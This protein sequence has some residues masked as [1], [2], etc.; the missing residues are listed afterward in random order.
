MK[1]VS[2]SVD[3]WCEYTGDS[4]VY[5]VYI[6]GDMLTERTFI[7]NTAAQYIREHIEVNLSSGVHWLTIENCSPGN[8]T[9]RT[10]NMQ[11]NGQHSSPK[12]NI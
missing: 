6:D 4:P 9:F 3:V 5:R 8:A 2:I 7:W 11:V 10:E 12:F 1:T